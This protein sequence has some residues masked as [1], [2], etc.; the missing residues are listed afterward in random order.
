MIDKYKE[1]LGYRK[2]HFKIRI[3]WITE[4]LFW[5]GKKLAFQLAKNKQSLY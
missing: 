3:I 1:L 5:Y 4:H 2:M